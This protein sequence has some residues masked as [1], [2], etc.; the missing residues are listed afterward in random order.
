MYPILSPLR[1][2][3]A[4]VCFFSSGKSVLEEGKR[5]LLSEPAQMYESFDIPAGDWV[6][7]PG[8]IL[9]WRI[10]TPG[11]SSQNRARA[12]S[13]WEAAQFAAH[14]QGVEYTLLL[15]EETEKKTE[16]VYHL[17]I[18]RSAHAVRG[19]ALVPLQAK[20]APL[21]KAYSGYSQ[22]RITQF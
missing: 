5:Y 11:P 15:G 16:R 22:Q 1:S 17:G 8:K 20:K 9:I 12:G 2:A 6:T 21:K 3:A 13:A 18:L 7:V 10:S 14:F 4:S 19:G